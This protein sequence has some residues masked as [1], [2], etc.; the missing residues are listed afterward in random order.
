MTA[1]SIVAPI[2]LEAIWQ[3][4]HF[5]NLKNLI[6]TVFFAQTQIARTALI[7]GQ[8]RRNGSESKSRTSVL[9][10]LRKVLL[11]PANSK[12]LI[13]WRY[14]WL[15]VRSRNAGADCVSRPPKSKI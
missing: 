14:V 8:Q 10:P 1:S 5:L 7:F 12:Y 11:S 2:K 15:S 6:C 13:F 4:H 3:A 9:T